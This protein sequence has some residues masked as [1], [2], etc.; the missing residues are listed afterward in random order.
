MS[1]YG[2]TDIG[3]GTKCSCP[4]GADAVRMALEGRARPACALHAP[5]LALAET[6]PA[7]GS[8]ALLETVRRCI[9]DDPAAGPDFDAGLRDD[10]HVVALRRALEGFTYPDGPQAA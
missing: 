10:G 1:E 4:S 9:G 8:D 3:D 5:D 7:L 6:G 2:V